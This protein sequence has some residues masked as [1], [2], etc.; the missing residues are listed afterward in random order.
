M[1]RSAVD[2]VVP[3]VGPPSE[4][5][6]LQRRLARLELRLGDTVLIVDNT[7]RTERVLAQRTDRPVPV[8]NA[9]E[10]RTP[11]YARNCGAARGSA[12]WIVFFD[13]DSDPAPDLLDR[14]FAPEPGDRTALLGGGVKDEPVPRDGLPAARYAY[15]R[16]AMS[17]DDTF[18]RDSGDEAAKV[19]RPHAGIAAKLIHLV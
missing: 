13:T 9:S 10:R 16:A 11:G 7:P 6:A 17:Q 5:E 15:I 14:Y 2:V 1:S 3:F 4:L 18:M 12:P 8:L 19:G